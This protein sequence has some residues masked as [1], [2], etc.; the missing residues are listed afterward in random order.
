MVFLLFILQG[1]PCAKKYLVGI[2]RNGIDYF[3]V[4]ESFLHVA[5]ASID[6]AQ[7]FLSVNVLSIL[8]AITFRRSRSDRAS[9][10]LATLQQL[11]LFLL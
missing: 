7:F 6:I 11:I 8:G 9:D 2:V 4:R 5:D 3:E 1:N 10:M